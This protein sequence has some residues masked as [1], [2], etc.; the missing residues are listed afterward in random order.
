MFDPDVLRKQANDDLA[1]DIHLYYTDPIY[2]RLSDYLATIRDEVES[3]QD[4]V[5][6]EEL[7]Q[8]I[9]RIIVADEYMRNIPG[10]AFDATD[11]YECYQ[12]I[13]GK[14]GFLNDVILNI[15]IK[16][17][18]FYRCRLEGKFEDVMGLD[19]FERIDAGTLADYNAILKAEYAILNLMLANYD[20][21]EVTGF[22]PEDKIKKEISNLGEQIDMIG[23]K[24]GIVYKG[25][26]QETKK[27]KS[28]IKDI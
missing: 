20:E 15:L 10:F 27:A 14:D 22:M 1:K 24:S 19:F 11:P 3:L 9:Y 18:E 25:I 17:K 28:N 21:L 13:L 7:T 23:K 12:R 2:D 5:K 6:N 16:D 26:L 8:N 4:I